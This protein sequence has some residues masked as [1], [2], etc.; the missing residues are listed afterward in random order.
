LGGFENTAAGG[1]MRVEHAARRSFHVLGSLR[2]RE[3]M[4]GPLEH[5]NVV[6]PVADRPHVLAPHAIVAGKPADSG[7][8]AG[9]TGAHHQPPLPFIAGAADL[10]PRAE[11]A[12]A[13]LEYFGGALCP[14]R[15]TQTD[16]RHH[17]TAS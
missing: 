9:A 14:F 4:A 7:A 17:L 6:E 5:R 2:H 13:L 8:F 15:W 11:Q 3:G 16:Q 12:R 10:E 1:R